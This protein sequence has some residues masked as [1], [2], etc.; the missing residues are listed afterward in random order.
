MLLYL[1]KGNFL[2]LWSHCSL[3]GKT[4]TWDNQVNILWWCG[5]RSHGHRERTR[6]GKVSLMS[7]THIPALR[8]APRLFPLSL[9]LSHCP[10]RSVC[11]SSLGQVC[12]E[13]TECFLLTAVTEGLENCLTQSRHS[14]NWVNEWMNEWQRSLK[15]KND[16]ALARG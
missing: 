6:G 11:L 4:V 12:F 2:F 7:S 14:G 10:M 16:Q 1:Q 8:D 3:K 5:H 9:S 13:G 15:Q